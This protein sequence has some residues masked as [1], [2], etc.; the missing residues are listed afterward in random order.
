MNDPALSA[1]YTVTAVYT[2]IERASA[3][4]EQFFLQ[5]SPSDMSMAEVDPATQISRNLQF[6]SEN[7]RSMYRG[8]PAVASTVRSLKRPTEPKRRP[9]AQRPRLR[10]VYRRRA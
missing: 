9:A 8:L 5:M 4:C 1:E 2:D 3:Y 6:I 10:S 7:L